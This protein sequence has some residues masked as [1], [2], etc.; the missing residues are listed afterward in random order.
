M[1]FGTDCGAFIADKLGGTGNIVMVHGVSG[2]APDENMFK[3][4]EMVLGDHPDLNVVATVV[5]EAFG[6]C[7]PGRIHKNTSKP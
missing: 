2:T 7:S 4:F 1:K 3:G 5:G 6:N